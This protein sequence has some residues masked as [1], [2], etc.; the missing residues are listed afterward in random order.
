MDSL[1]NKKRIDYIDLSKGICI[2]LVVLTHSESSFEVTSCFDF[3]LTSFRMPLY[4]MLSG[5]F[6]KDYDTIYIFLRKKINKLLIPFIFFYVVI[7]LIFPLLTKNIRP[8]LVKNEGIEY[9]FSLYWENMNGMP[10]GIWFL[11]CLFLVNIFFYILYELSIGWL[12]NNK[13]LSLTFLITAS[14]LLGSLG[15]YLGYNRINLPLYI[16]S[17]LTSLPFFCCGYLLRQK[18]NILYPNKY[19]KYLSIIS[20]ILFVIV[21]T[22]ADDFVSFRQNHYNINLLYLYVCGIIGALAILLIGKKINKIRYISFMGRYSIMILCSHQIILLFIVTLLKH[23]DCEGWFA[24]IV[25]FIITSVIS[26]IL[27]YPMK[28]YFPYVTAQKDLL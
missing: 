16:D 25:S 8:E 27:I 17:A 7:A 20:I 12:E 5:L 23:F 22:L 24:T 6:F 21:F 15:F 1:T 11:W 14:L 2:L 26:Y 10:M 28:K 3:A 13:H 4:F 19:D 18:T 9:F